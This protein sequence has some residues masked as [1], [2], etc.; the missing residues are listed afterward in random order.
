MTLRRLSRIAAVLT[1]ALV[2]F[3]PSSDPRVM[4]HDCEAWH[5][6]TY[7]GTPWRAVACVPDGLVFEPGRVDE[8]FIIAEPPAGWLI[9]FHIRACSLYDCS[10]WVASNTF[11][12]LEAITHDDEPIEA[13]RF[14]V[15][16]EPSCTRDA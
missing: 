2:I 12:S 1:L 10:D 15:L 14:R 8:T 3:T 7:A 9:A 6:S 4:R 13:R 16:R 5:V 11:R